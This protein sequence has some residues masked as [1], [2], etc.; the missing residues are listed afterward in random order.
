MSVLQRC[1]S[2]EISFPRGFIVIMKSNFGEFNGLVAGKYEIPSVIPSVTEKE[3][4]DKY[5]VPRSH[6]Y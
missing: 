6:I 2:Y 1:P 3:F 5:F 4:T